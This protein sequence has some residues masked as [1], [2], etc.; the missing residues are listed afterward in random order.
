MKK[1][2]NKI[3][4]ELLKILMTNQQKQYCL[5]S[6]RKPFSSGIMKK[7]YIKNKI[8]ISIYINF[9]NDIERRKD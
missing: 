3:R 9:G 5:K 1:K 4:K 6:K 7:I 8:Y 2:Y